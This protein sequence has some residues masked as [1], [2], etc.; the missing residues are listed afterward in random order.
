MKLYRV[1]VGIVGALM[2]STSVWA[3][4]TGCV[5][6]CDFYCGNGWPDDPDGEAACYNGCTFGCAYACFPE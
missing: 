3:G 6:A 5:A 2:L 1:A 4:C